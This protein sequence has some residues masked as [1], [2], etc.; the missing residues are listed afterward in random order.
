[1]WVFGNWV[2]PIGMNPFWARG[3]ESMQTSQKPRT[4]SAETI[5]E[6]INTR[7]PRNNL[8]SNR[9]IIE[10]PVG[11]AAKF[12]HIFC[13][14]LSGRK[15]WPESNFPRRPAFRAICRD[16]VRLPLGGVA[17]FPSGNLVSK[18]LLPGHHDQTHVVAL[19]L[20]A[21]KILDPVQQPLAQKDQIQRVGF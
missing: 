1:M 2:F 11:S 20:T 17:R 3:T 9:P 13:D 8:Y 4:R 5:I 6:A 12:P 15:E 18:I 14:F 21:D 16:D 10:L 7:F 19:R